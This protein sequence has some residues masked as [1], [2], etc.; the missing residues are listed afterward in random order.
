MARTI[1]LSNGNL[2]VG[3]DKFAQVSDFYFP[4]NGYNNHTMGKDLF[5]R[6]GLMVDGNICWLNN[7]EWEFDSS[8]QDKALI[9]DIT[10]TNPHRQLKIQF[11]DLVASDFDALLRQVTVINTADYDRE[12]K[13]FLHQNF[14]IN[15]SFHLADTA[16][17]LPSEH[18]IMH[19]RGDRAFVVSAEV[20]RHQDHT[21]YG[22]FDQHTV[23]LFGIEGLKGSWLD[24]EDGELAGGSVE[25]GRTD[26]V[27]RLSSF[28][29]AGQQSVFNYRI[30]V[31]D[32]HATA[33]SS[34]L[35][36]KGD[37]FN[38]TVQQTTDYWRKWLEP[39]ERLIGRLDDK[40]RSSFTK[41]LLLTKSHLSNT[42]TPIASNDSEMLNKA[43]DGYS[44]CWPRD[45]L[46]A[47]WPLVRL[48]YKDE[49]LRFFELAAE[50]MI[51]PEGFI[52]HKYLPNGELG[53]TWHPYSTEPGQEAL[54]VQLDE[55]AGIL[56]L[57]GQ[58]YN[59]FHDEKALKQY[60]KTLVKPMADF[61][62]SYTELNGLPKPS[63]ELWEMNY[64]NTTY[65][66]SIVYASL[67]TAA[68]LARVAGRAKD[69][70]NWQSAAKKMRDAARAELFNHDRQYFYR[71]I[72]PNGEKD[73]LIDASSFYGAFIFGLFDFDS[74]EVR[75][76]L[77]TLEARFDANFQTGLPRH[78]HD[79]YLRRDDSYDGNFWIITSLWRAEYYL[80]VGEVE[81]AREILDWVMNKQSQAGVFPEQFEPDTGK[82]LSVSPLTWSQAEWV[83]AL[84]D[85]IA[86]SE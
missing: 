76:S 70:L 7:G 61:L 35:K 34:N 3:L 5:H 19:Y 54:P 37:G 27:I 84:I 39:A 15:A 83:S 77:D 79:I 40:Y 2:N 57:F 8:Y 4:D 23:G 81:K 67:E 69:S 33:I 64:L 25:H 71:G 12:I 65:T 46:Y 26:S 42:G 52:A 18:A 62:S 73:Q 48:G 28:I 74:P 85:L 6:I 44:Y 68:E 20:V 58:F 53:P 29:A 31:A 38:N 59:K 86:I 1:I 32:G 24:A 10:A 50:K 45:A 13:L 56:F 63:Y 55:T 41:S 9:S 80:N 49:P 66:T 78:E 82:W 51:R 72:W 36:L 11:K 30:S 43:R 47:L 16:I 17:Y 14:A 75:Q 21:N 60:Y 22:S